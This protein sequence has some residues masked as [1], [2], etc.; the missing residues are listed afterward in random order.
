MTVYSNYMKIIL[1]FFSMLI[2]VMIVFVIYNQILTN[3]IKEEM[4]KSLEEQ[5][6]YAISKLDKQF[7]DLEMD[8]TKLYLEDSFKP[9][10]NFGNL[11]A[12]EQ[13][14]LFESL[15]KKHNSSKNIATMAVL[16]LGQHQIVSS[17]AVRTKEEFFDRYYLNDI[18][19]YDF[20]IEELNE[21]FTIRY[22]PA[23]IFVDKG[24]GMNSVTHTYI[25][26]ALKTK[27]K[28]DF[29]MIAYID[30]EG[31]CEEVEQLFNTDFIIYNADNKLLYPTESTYNQTEY[32]D[33]LGS[34]KQYFQKIK[35]DYVKVQ[36]SHFNDF[37]YVKLTS[38][39]VLENKMYRIFQLEI[40]TI[41]GV[42]FIGGIIAAIS[43]HSINLPVKEISNFFRTGMNIKESN[44]EFEYIKT[45]VKY[46]I[47][48]NKRYANI[49]EEKEAI[50]S[51]F[52]NYA[53]LK[54][55]YLNISSKEDRDENKAEDYFV[56]IGIRIIYRKEYRE[57]T[58]SSL[59]E[60]SYYVRDEIQH[61]LSQVFKN[62]MLF[63]TE[64][65]EIIIK[66]SGTFNECSQI[67][68]SL[69]KLMTRF[70]EEKEYAVIYIFV[71]DIYSSNRSLHEIYKQ[72]EDVTQYYY[73]NQENQILYQRG[74]E[75]KEGRLYFTAEENDQFHYLI[76]NG[77][78]E[79]AIKL[80][81]KILE[82]NYKKGIK[83]YYL[84]MLYIQFIN[85][86]NQILLKMYHEIPNEIPIQVAYN[87]AHNCNFYEEFEHLLIEFISTVTAYIQN[88]LG[89]EDPIISKIEEFIEENYAEEFT[90]DQ[91][92]D[93]VNL[94]RSYMS[95]YYKNKTSTNLSDYIS[96]YRIK[97]AEKL[98]ISTQIKFSEIGEQVG[99]YNQNTF[100]RLFKKY[101]GCA[102][103]EY[104]KL[105]MG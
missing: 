24:F 10:K 21:K 98:V 8:L 61:Q 6:N 82:Y 52:V 39:E 26:I 87:N 71:S 14:R 80:C 60:V 47:E 38:N 74:K 77:Q 20:W 72:V 101:I 58:K 25:P 33:L 12:Y 104:R 97:Q 96:Y 64:N 66:I 43:A 36:R 95:T 81:K 69:N 40:W 103:S 42:F 1:R 91:L 89:G 53:A 29:M 51:E 99:I 41:I 56:L 22:Y 62:L 44:N 85:I 45:N 83:K 88:H 28:S 86:I 79:A 94:S 13:Y 55:V 84:S 2:V 16:I 105:H 35:Q 78:T 31:I 27:E 23:A 7:Y 4:Q 68:K 15:N 48:Q 9:L 100:T 18:Y 50:I 37:V 57:N 102:P 34:R 5:I 11:S 3:T 59:S 67:E 49:L 92:A 90:L 93:Y 76:L 46:M 75:Y 54:N 65:S 30:I 19:T 17:E 70:E 32:L 63:Q 73:M